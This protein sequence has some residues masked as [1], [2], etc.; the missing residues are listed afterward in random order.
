MALRRE[1]RIENCTATEP[2]RFPLLQQARVLHK[3]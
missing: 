1:E 2:H 3:K